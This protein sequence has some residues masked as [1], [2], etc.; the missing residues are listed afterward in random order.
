MSIPKAGNNRLNYLIERFVGNSFT[1]AEM[2]ELL[3]FVEEGHGEQ[4]QSALERQWQVARERGVAAETNWDLL[5][6][7][8]M[9]QSRRM[10]G[11][12]QLSGAV[13]VDGSGQ[14]SGVPEMEPAPRRRRSKRRRWSAIAVVFL[15]LIGG[16]AAFRIFYIRPA[17][18]SRPA[19]VT[20]RYKNDV[21]PGGDK[22]ILTLADGTSIVL[23]SANNGTLSMQGNTKVLKLGSGR[24]T[25][26]ATHHPPGD[27]SLV[28]NT[29]STPRGGQYQI[30]LPDGSKV[31]LNATSSLRF[32]TAFAG[33][34]RQ[35]QLSGEAYFEVAASAHQPFSVAVFAGEPGKGQPLQQVEVLGTQFDVM[36]YT[37]ENL[38]K[39]TLLT[40]AVQIGGVFGG[41]KTQLAPGEQAQ[42]VRGSGAGAG[43]SGGG[44][45]VSGAGA[46]ASSVHVVADADAD[47]DA[48]IAWKNGYF[49]FNKADIQT[50]MRQLSR[51]YDVEVS[52]RGDESKGRI[53]WGG[54][55]RNLPLSAVF[56]IL[57][58]SGVQFAIDG[59]KVVVNL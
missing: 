21:Q 42:L 8:M 18:A 57:D 25:Y 38:V 45:G 11:A 2:E 28:Y 59:K 43:V 32:P 52:F 49:D 33:R 46:G 5:F 1:R 23:D 10:D 53:F 27:A 31:W 4:L 50:I 6:Q 36:A 20:R 30:E 19:V 39:T 44:A 40:G 54:I 12:D 34:E 15:F 3:R 26:E 48:A 56:G 16:G 14:L 37:D 29:I 41:R 51:W 9:L 13:E 47:V 55:Q 35:V 22:A 58:K 24:L 17:Q 7:R